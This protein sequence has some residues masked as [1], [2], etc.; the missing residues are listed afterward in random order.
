MNAVAPRAN[1]RMA[2]AEILS[3]T[4]DAPEEMFHG[5]MTQFDP[6]L[7]SPATVYLAHESCELTGEVLPPA[8][9]R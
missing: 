3:D 1:T 4:Y 7:V 2:T 5:S 8:A 6:D 9:A